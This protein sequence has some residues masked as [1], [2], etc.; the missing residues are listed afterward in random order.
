[1]AFGKYS[2]ETTE[3]EAVSFLFTLVRSE[4]NRSDYFFFLSLVDDIKGSK[5]VLFEGEPE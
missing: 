2:L 1:V 5:Y 3:R 4:V